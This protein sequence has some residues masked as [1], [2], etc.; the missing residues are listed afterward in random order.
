MSKEDVIELEGTVIEAK[1]NATFLVELSN[2]HKIL[3][4]KSEVNTY[5]MMGF[6][7]VK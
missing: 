3:V 4:K 1:P 7:L 6:K 5:K 2:G